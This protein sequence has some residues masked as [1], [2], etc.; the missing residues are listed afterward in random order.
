ML[1]TFDTDISMHQENRLFQARIL[2]STGGM[3]ATNQT[4]KK[5]HAG[6]DDSDGVSDA[7]HLNCPSF[8]NYALIFP[9]LTAVLISPIWLLNRAKSLV[10]I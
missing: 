4:R 9:L 5:M 3:N 6:V 7:R 10:G 1:S 2:P 8:A